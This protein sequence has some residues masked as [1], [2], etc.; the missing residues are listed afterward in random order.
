L[1][2]I[3]NGVELDLMILFGVACA[4]AVSEKC[5]KSRARLNYSVAVTV[6]PETAG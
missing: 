3:L 5:D 1:N 6:D 4:L 2:W